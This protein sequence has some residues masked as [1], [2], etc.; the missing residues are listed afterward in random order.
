[1]SV[2]LA[3]ARAETPALELAPTMELRGH[4][5]WVRT[6]AFHPEGR[7]LASGGPDRTVRIWDLEQAAEAATLR[8]P[9]YG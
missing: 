4:D 5:G 7:R 1:V 9:R 2:V 3:A 6:L 8:L